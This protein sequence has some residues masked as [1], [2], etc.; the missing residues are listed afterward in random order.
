MTDGS[1]DTIFGMDD[2]EL[3][4]RFAEAVRLANEKKLAMGVPLP[5]YDFASGRAYLLY[6]DGHREYAD[7]S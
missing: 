3:D 1:D 7:A 6:G 4:R 5:K 2:E